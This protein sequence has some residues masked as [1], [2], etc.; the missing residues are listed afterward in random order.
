MYTHVQNVLLHYH[1]WELC[2]PNGYQATLTEN[3]VLFLSLR[4][5]NVATAQVEGKWH[6]LTATPKLTM[7]S[8]IFSL[9]WAAG[10]PRGEPQYLKKGYRTTACPK[11]G[12]RVFLFISF[13]AVHLRL[14]SARHNHSGCG[15]VK[16]KGIISLKL[17][18][19]FKLTAW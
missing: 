18:K 8:H 1:C 17:P 13:W 11:Q 5:N 9:P 2:F 6:F 19:C 15:P 16:C 3:S 7:L 10:K 14:S 4:E 12:D